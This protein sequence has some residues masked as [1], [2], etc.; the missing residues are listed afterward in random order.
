M[1]I[2]NK[3]QYFSRASDA[4][5][6]AFEISMWNEKNVIWIVNLSDSIS[7]APRELK[8][9]AA[10]SPEASKL[11]IYDKFKK[12]FWR[13]SMLGNGLQINVEWKMLFRRISAISELKQNERDRRC[14]NLMVKWWIAYR[15]RFPLW[16]W[17]RNFSDNNWILGRS[18]AYER[19]ATVGKHKSQKLLATL[20]PFSNRL[21][22]RRFRNIFIKKHSKKDFIASQ[23]KFHLRQRR[24]QDINHSES[25]K[26]LSFLRRLSKYFSLSSCRILMRSF[27]VV[28]N[29]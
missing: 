24:Q 12:C 18:Q 3:K 7:S 8:A 14:W 11:L 21:S 15:W 29:I 6:F 10:V 22:K 20:T 28:E 16:N 17:S 25:Q 9:A 13:L 5:D 27:G 1:K 19:L 4:S 2:K 23:F 26:D